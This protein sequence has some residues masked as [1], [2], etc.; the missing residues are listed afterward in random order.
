MK[1][2]WTG[3]ILSGLA[4]AFLAMDLTMKVMRA[5]DH[6]E[7]CAS[8]EKDRITHAKETCRWH[9]TMRAGADGSAC[10]PMHIG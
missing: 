6:A 7:A 9:C 1:R 3:R 10:S 5:G 2:R 8:A 4:A